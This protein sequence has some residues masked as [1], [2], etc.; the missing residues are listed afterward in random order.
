MTFKRTQLLNFQA[1]AG[2]V[3]LPLRQ[4]S[5]P[6]VY[7]FA[8]PAMN[9]PFPADLNF[10][11][12]TVYTGILVSQQNK[13]GHKMYS[14]SLKYLKK[15]SNQNT[16]TVLF[17]LTVIFSFLDKTCYK[18]I[19]GVTLECLTTF[20]RLKVRSS[21]L[22]YLALFFLYNKEIPEGI[23]SVCRMCWCM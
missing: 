21:H 10:R 3:P 4:E 11:E 22:L 5:A 23:Y 12:N 20:N 6:L 19:T 16:I 7:I 9:G 2:H 8:L 1:R 14:L 15:N 17:I 13:K 18:I